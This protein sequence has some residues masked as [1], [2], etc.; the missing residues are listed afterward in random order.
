[1]QGDTN[2]R[3]ITEIKDHA[4]VPGVWLV[5]T[6]RTKHPKHN[7][8]PE[9]Q[10]PSAADIQ[11]Q[12]LNHHVIE[13]ELFDRTLKIKGAETLRKRSA[14]LGI[15]YGQSWTEEECRLGD[16]IVMAYQNKLSS[17][18]DIID[19]IHTKTSE[20]VDIALL[21]EVKDKI[22]KTNEVLLLQDLPHVSQE[23]YTWLKQNQKPHR[24]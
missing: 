16:L 14:A 12:R 3:Q 19:F 24:K 22:D 11:S 7:Y 4:H 2:E 20:T 1:M 10:W 21:H 18:L 6:S 23:Q 17:V 9:D 13:A 5:A 15:S 8:I